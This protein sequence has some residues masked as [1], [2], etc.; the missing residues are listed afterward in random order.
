LA[1]R[2]RD[3]VALLPFHPITAV[4]AAKEDGAVMA[5][6]G[7]MAA[8]VAAAAMAPTALPSPSTKTSPA[9]LLPSPIASSLRSPL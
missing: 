4:R 3:F 6:A 2:A 9:N 5:A 1:L 8:V 7:A